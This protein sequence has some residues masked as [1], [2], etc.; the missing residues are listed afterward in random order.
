VALIGEQA[1]EK[2]TAN[3]MA[4]LRRTIAYEVLCN[5]GARVPRVMVD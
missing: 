4:S 1:T 5:I 2:I 3:E